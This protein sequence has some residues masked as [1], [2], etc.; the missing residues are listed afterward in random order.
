MNVSVSKIIEVTGK[1]VRG[2]ELRVSGSNGMFSFGVNQ[3]YKKQ[4]DWIYTDELDDVI[5]AL[6]AFRD[7]LRTKQEV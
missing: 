5:A 1:T 3:G 6:T 2:K 4:E 7:T